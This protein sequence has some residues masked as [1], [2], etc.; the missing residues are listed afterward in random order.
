MKSGSDR[1]NFLKTT[2]A[3]G[4][5]LA[6]APGTILRANFSKKKTGVSVGFIG[7]GGH[8]HHLI[9]HVLKLNHVAVTAICDIK[10]ENLA[11]GQKMVEEA[12]GN[13]PAGYGEHEYIYREMLEKEALDAVLIA[14]PWRWH[15]PM[16]IDTMRHGAYAAVEAGPASTV[17]ECWDMVNTAHSTGLH[18]MLLENHCYDR[19]NM[20]VLNMVRQGVFGELLHCHCGYEHDLRG[21]IVT[22]KG[23]GVTRP[24]AAG[25]DYRTLQNM[26]R[27]GDLYPTHGIGPV[28]QCL[29]IHRGNRFTGLVSMSTKSRG[30]GLWAEEN[31]DAGHPAQAFDWHMGDI[32][33]T[34][35]RCYNGETVV[36]SFDTRSP[37]PY[38]N[39][40][41]VQGTK[42]IWLQDGNA[43]SL[44]KSVIYVEG[45]SPHHEWEPFEPYQEKYEHQLW[46]RY[47]KEG[48]VEGHRGSGFLKVKGFIEAVRQQVRPPI[49]TYD[50]AAWKAISPLSEQS[51][52]QGN[53]SVQFPDFTNRKWMTDEPIFGLTDQY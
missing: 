29:D 42:A 32:V 38:S 46:K 14:T 9:E 52:Q 44:D 17:K 13:R 15:I 43:S 19:W 33:T 26:K 25:G 21:R 11:R 16:A 6:L 51:I 18:T 7:V 34:M 40:R 30:L 22:G 31:L 48:V 49:D 39:M 53:Q 8:G 1:R 27:N 20:A 3:A 4:M 41:R 35:I 23:T 37:R 12:T 28:S 45:K 50:T 2:T 24:E 47:L 10:E 5:G 36:M